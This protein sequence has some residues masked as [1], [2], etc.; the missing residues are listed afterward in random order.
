MLEE[1]CMLVG[2]HD[3]AV[4]LTVNDGEGVQEVLYIHYSGWV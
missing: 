4:H 3:M 2:Y 1:S